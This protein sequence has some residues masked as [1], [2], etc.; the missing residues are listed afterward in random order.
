MNLRFPL[1]SSLSFSDTL[2]PH[3]RRYRPR[4]SVSL[5][6]ARETPTQDPGPETERALQCVWFDERFRPKSLKTTD[7]EP[8]Q[9]EYPGRWNLGPGPDFLDAALRLG[10]GARRIEGDVEVHVRPS[11]WTAHGHAQDPR[12][13]RVRVHVTYFGGAL[14]PAALPAGAVQI[15]LREALMATPLFSF[16]Q[17]DPAAYPYAAPTQP[18]PCA[19]VLAGWTPDEKE[20]LLNAAGEERLRRRAERLAAAV[21]ERGADQVFYEE[22][23]VALGYP[24]NKVPFRRLAA[25]LPLERLRSEAGDDA[26][27]AEALL[28]GAAGLLSEGWKP[29][30]SV[31]AR[32]HA[33]R[34]WDHWWKSPLSQRGVR[35]DPSEWRLAGARPA[36][37]PARRIAGAA[38]FFSRWGHPADE[39]RHRASGADAAACLLEWL[40]V[41][42]G[43]FWAFHA[44]RAGR[45]SLKPAALIGRARATA[46]LINVCV[47]LLAA[48]DVR[49]PFDAGWLD[50][51]PPEAPSDRLRLMARTLFGAGHPPSL[52]DTGLRRQGLLQIFQDYCLHNRSHCAECEFPEILRRMRMR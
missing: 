2:F 46:I 51:L 34:L 14:P 49:A 26:E 29:G 15:A 52:Y 18:A 32:R 13:A 42:A 41:R 4:P 24:H 48:L 25:L 9:V 36:N 11:D 37:H 31:E 39:L 44:S 21:V 30:W 50:R 40:D 22:Y 35:V 23:L 47:P 3:A 7:G 5:G 16:D 20:A 1:A 28:A 8:V 38:T 6:H 10:A 19:A 12:Y 43:T 27:K 17:I 33:R 45:A